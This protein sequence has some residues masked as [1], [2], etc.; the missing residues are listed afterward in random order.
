MH[1]RWYGQSAFL[2]TGQEHRVFVDPFGDMSGLAAR[3]IDWHYAPI[4]G[5]SA[6][7]LLVTHDHLDHNAVETIGGK[8]VVLGGPGTH[9]SPIGEVVGI[10]SEH[11]P[12]AGTQRGA[13]TI[14]R[15]ALD[16]LAVAHLGDFGQNALRPEQENAIERVDVL[17]VP[18]GAGP[19]LPVDAAAD[20][21]RRL[22]PRLVVPMHYRTPA[23]GF[24]DPPEPFLDAL[25]VD[26]VRLPTNELGVEEHLGPETI[27]TLLAPPEAA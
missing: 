14:F 7:L 26:V 27:V 1:V 23:I 18:V 6:D 11:D 13:N 25:G 17:F 21:V 2:L 3:G 5:V 10:A 8:P 22:A 12:A 19:T 24:L 16:G 9:E 15:F 20:L 4:D